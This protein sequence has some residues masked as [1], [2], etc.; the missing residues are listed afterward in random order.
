ANGQTAYR[1]GEYF[2]KEL[3]V[4]NSSAALWTNI[5]VAATGQTSV[6]GAVFVAKTA[7]AF[8]YD[9][10]G[11]MTNDGHWSLTWDTENRLTQAE[12]LSNSPA[13]SKRKVAW[14]FDSKG[15]RIR[16]TTY[17]GSSGSFVVT[18]D[19]KFISDG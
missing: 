15:R 10:D 18:E 17:D 13:A 6:T 1:K 7:E 11:N 8:G 5:T 3:A 4:N 16:Q 9:T 19:L 2:R 12:S 14:E